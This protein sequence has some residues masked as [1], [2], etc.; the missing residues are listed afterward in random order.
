MYLNPSVQ[1][2]AYSDLACLYV[3]WFDGV[4]VFFN[5]AADDGSVVVWLSLKQEVG[6]AVVADTEL[7][8]FD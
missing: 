6:D 8:G 7:H 5:T 2:F 4:I 3:Q 1:L